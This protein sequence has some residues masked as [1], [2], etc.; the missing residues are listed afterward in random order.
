MSS[1]RVRSPAAGRPAGQ[2]AVIFAT[3]TAV[4]VALSL[5]ISPDLVSPGF[6]SAFAILTGIG[7]LGTFATWLQQTDRSHSRLLRVLESIRRC[8][9]FENGSTKD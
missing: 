9:A 8:L 6:F 1:C 7:A 4:L 2:A 3:V 5:V